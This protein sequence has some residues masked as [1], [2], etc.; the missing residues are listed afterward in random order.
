MAL[1]TELVLLGLEKH[2]WLIEGRFIAKSELLMKEPPFI[3]YRDYLLHLFRKNNGRIGRSELATMPKHVPLETS[4]EIF[5]Q[6]ACFANDE[7]WTLRF[8]KDDLFIRQYP[9]FATRQELLN[10]ERDKK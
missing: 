10:D 4:R 6:I 5:K 8:E 1:E 9:S 2:A 7:R 3:L